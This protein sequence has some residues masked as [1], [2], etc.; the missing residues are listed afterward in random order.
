MIAKEE[1]QQKSGEESG[2][3]PRNGSAA[4]HPE[5]DPEM[6]AELPCNPRPLSSLPEQPPVHRVRGTFSARKPGAQEERAWEGRPPSQ[7]VA[8][9]FQT[10]S[11]FRCASSRGEMADSK[12]T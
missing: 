10:E 11:Q 8:Q 2:L 9:Q 4:S 3:E 7:H 6:L 1:V 5:S 12:E